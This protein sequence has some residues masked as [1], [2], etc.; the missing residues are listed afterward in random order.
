MTRS[1]FIFQTLILT[2]VLL[3]LSWWLGASLTFFSNDVGLRFLQVRELVA[4]RWQSFAIDYPARPFD[5]DWEFVPFYYAYSL[6][7]G[8][9]YFNITP[10]LP[11]LASLFY[12][13][14]GEW[15]L[16]V[17]PVLGGVMTAVAGHQLA[18]LARLPRPMLVMV[19]TIFATPLLFYSLELWDHSL[20]AALAMW[21][22]VG[23][24][25]GVKRQA[26]PPI[27][28]GGVAAGMGLGQRPEMVVFAIALGAG[29]LAV[30]W[31]RLPLLATGG[32]AG[33]LPIWLLQWRWVGHPLGMVF[34]PM[35]FGYGR[36]PAYPVES[37]SGVAITPA[38]RIGRLLFWVESRDPATF[39]ALLLAVA[40][41]GLIVLTV[42]VPGWRR[43]SLL[44]AG[45][46]GMTAAYGLLLWRAGTD[47]IPGL[48]S[49]LPLVG[50][51]LAFVN[52]DGVYRLAL[53]V[54]LTFLGL[55][56]ALWPSFGGE[57]WGARY[58]LPAVPLLLFLAFY[59]WD[60]YGRLL[61][62]EMK[63]A[64]RAT[65]VTL[66]L[67]SVAVQMA[68]IRTQWRQHRGQ[69]AVQASIA[70]LPADIILMNSPFLPSYMTGLPDKIFMYV[71]DEADVAALIPRLAAGRVRRVALLPVENLP[72]AMPMQIGEWRLKE[73]A[74]LVYA[75]ERE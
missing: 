26:W 28:W 8:R 43:P 20:A 42:R 70:R 12:V 7:D 13:V 66:L 72:L 41:I 55:M 67:L 4:H 17:I 32:L 27:F 19:A 21:A 2:A 48:I 11:F 39:A 24:A 50:L 58:L 52:T 45:L 64:W 68:G 1:K 30:N 3:G 65:A 34:A 69:A 73:V 63:R 53:T 14:L 15:G 38:L 59:A 71:A 36:P 60:W 51:S 25:A 46:A 31:R 23:V 35:F 75:M 40:G 9:L 54:T 33:A 10:F 37:Y 44:W 29:L 56:L 6:L 16:S 18:R 57:Q 5:P 62:G 22:V 74:P 61:T 49:T 47:P